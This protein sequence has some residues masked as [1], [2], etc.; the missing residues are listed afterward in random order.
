MNKYLN[1]FNELVNSFQQLSTSLIP[2]F[3]K[4][5]LIVNSNIKEDI[6]NV[7]ILKQEEQEQ[8]IHIING[9]NEK[10]ELEHEVLCHTIQ[11]TKLQKEYNQKRQ[12]LEQL[13][14]T[15]QTNLQQIVEQTLEQLLQQLNKFNQEIKQ[16]VTKYQELDQEL[17]QIIIKYQKV[18]SIQNKLAQD[19]DNKLKQ[20]EELINNHQQTLKQIIKQFDLFFIIQPIE[21][22]KKDVRRI[23]KIQLKENN[24]HEIWLEELKKII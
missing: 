7:K 12:Q 21:D 22:A 13:K 16:G 17:E 5:L 2:L 8:A 19:Y 14:Q 10:E 15:L 24:I 3:E 4:E 23:K 18:E 20:I 6:D 9:I 1:Q 11:N